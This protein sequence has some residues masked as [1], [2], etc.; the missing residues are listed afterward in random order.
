MNNSQFDKKDWIYKSFLVETC[1]EKIKCLENAIVEDPH[2]AFVWHELG[3]IYANIDYNKAMHCWSRASESYEKR[4]EQFKDDAQKFQKNPN[5]LL[6]M[7]IDSA[8]MKY[9]ISLRL[10]NLGSCLANLDKHSL[11]SKMFLKSFLLDSK[12]CNAIYYA[13]K[14]LYESEKFSDAHKYLTTY[15]ELVND[16]KA[17]C[18]LGMICWKQNKIHD[19]QNCFWNCID[20]SGDDV[21]GFYHK[22]LAFSML[23]NDKLAESY[24]KNAVFQDLDNVVMI[25]NLIVFYEENDMPKRAYRYYRILHQRKKKQK[26]DFKIL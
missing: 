24:L 2:D 4:L 3:D 6:F 19:A 9:E 17:W 21:D 7:D 18:L 13:A 15:L 5:H 23:G 10:Y 25:E 14:E 8:D 1:S 20:Q 22:H 26:N 11:A 12:M 16:Y